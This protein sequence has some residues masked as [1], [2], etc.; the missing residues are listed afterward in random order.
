[1]N[2]FR[3]VEKISASSSSNDHVGSIVISSVEDEFL[4][5]PDF[6]LI[7]FLG[8]ISTDIYEDEEVVSVGEGTTVTRGKRAANVQKKL[9]RRNKIAKTAKKHSGHPLDPEFFH[10]DRKGDYRLVYH[11][12]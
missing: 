5:N 2:L 9:N 6:M 11:F 4:N 1:M 10:F 8:T 3:Y 12:L 7:G